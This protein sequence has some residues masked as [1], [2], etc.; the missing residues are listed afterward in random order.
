MS[1]ASLR[2]KGVVSFRSLYL[3]LTHRGV[4]TCGE[5][6]RTRR[7]SLSPGALSR[8]CIFN[9]TESSCEIEF[10]SGLKIKGNKDFP[11]ASDGKAYNVVG[12]GSIPGRE[13]PLEKEMATPTPVL[14]PGKSHGHW[15]LVGYSPWGRKESDTTERLNFQFQAIRRNVTLA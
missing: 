5:S 4:G 6:L 15:S 10:G 8:I 13:D 12:P 3:A 9:Q 11:G 1:A 14:L 2:R 7:W